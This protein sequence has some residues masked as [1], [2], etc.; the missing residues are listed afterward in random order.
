[1]NLHI[2]NPEHDLILANNTKNYTPSSGI[3]K[4]R[5]SFSYV[6]VFWASRGDVI[7]TDDVGISVAENK[8]HG[9][10]DA[11]VIFCTL[12]DLHRFKFDSI[13]P[14]GWDKTLKH[15]LI[16]YGVD[17]ALMP[18]DE[19]LNV[20]RNMSH[21]RNVLPLM[22]V[23]RDG[24]EDCTCGDGLE[25]FSVDEIEEV[26]STWKRIVIKAP[27]SSSGINIIYVEGV[28]S[29]AMRSRCSHLIDKQGSVMTEP[30]Y[31]KV[32]DFAMEFY[33]DGKGST[34]YLGLSVFETLGTAYLNNMVASEEDKL[35]VLS[36]YVSPALLH[37][38]QSRIC[39]YMSVVCTSRY[40]GPF[41]VDMMVVSQ[42]GTN[43]ID[44]CVEINLRRTMGHVA[45]ERWK[46]LKG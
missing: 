28:L 25:C 31:N 1:M 2:F 19:Q 35:K 20:I 3:L 38:I 42:N 9:I 33:S 40:R 12:N 10:P 7:L 11:D 36:E 6:P 17:S 37:E 44:P 13:N 43:V 30:L 23:L 26:L 32:K 15:S 24:Q 34:E 45:L 18:S 29:D 8:A 4:M 5:R 14:W 41:G 22:Q 16:R 27:W 39:S 46:H 21:R